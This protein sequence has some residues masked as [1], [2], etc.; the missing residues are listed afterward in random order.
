MGC[1]EWRN[2]VVLVGAL[3]A[4]GCGGSEKKPEAPE[5]EVSE[6]VDDE[7]VELVPVEKIEEIKS[8]FER[9]ASSVARCFPIA[10]ES[11]EVDPNERVQVSV[12][13][14]IQPD[15][16]PSKVRILGSSKRSKALETCVIESVQRWEFIT[17]PIPLEYSY[18]FKLQR[19]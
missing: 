14:V 10:V 8:I 17:L 15:G 7:E 3:V 4:L 13:L 2:K 16:S 5:P 19:F 18:G 11:G 6:E 9:R 12:G 1:I